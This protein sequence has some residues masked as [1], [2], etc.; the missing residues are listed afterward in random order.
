MT[1]KFLG[2]FFTQPLVKKM[3]VEL[4]DPK[5][6]EDG[7]IESCADPA[8]GTAG[9][10]VTYLKYIVEKAKKNNINLDWNR[11]KIDGLYGKE[12]E[13]DTYKLA[14]S[15]MLISSG[16]IFDRLDRGDSIRDPIVRKFDNILANPPFGIRGLNYDE[17]THELKLEYIP[18]KTNNAVSLFIQ[19]IIYMLKIGGKCAVVLPDG[20]DLF[21]TS[22][23]SLVA[24]REYLLKTCDLQEIIYL[25]SGIFTYTSINTC[26]FYFVKKVEGSTILDVNISYHKTTNQEKKRTYKFCSEH[27]TSKV[28][29]CEYNFDNNSKNIIVEASIE[30]IFKNSYSLNYNDYVEFTQDSMNL[31]QNITLRKIGEICKIQQGSSLTKAKMIDGPYDVIGGGKIIGKHNEF[32]RNGGDISYSSR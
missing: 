9:F 5:I 21:S 6:N 8:M 27:Q 14:I 23:K 22:N 25:P 31:N 11:I 13:P 30:E 29:F 7:T 4:I 28:K 32:N 24:I 16:H 26:V 1:G 17:I 18:I 3:M 15:N 10:L 12:L 19:A 2:Q 20:Q